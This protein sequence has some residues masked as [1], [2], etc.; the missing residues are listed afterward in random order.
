M[1]YLIIYP[2]INGEHNFF[3]LFQNTE[4]KTEQILQP[5]H[6]YKYKYF[7]KYIRNLQKQSEYRT[8][9]HKNNQINEVRKWKTQAK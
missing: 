8:K 7:Y 3:I 9:L 4:I 6:K 2:K 1:N 5:Q